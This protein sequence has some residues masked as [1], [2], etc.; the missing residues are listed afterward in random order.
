MKQRTISFDTHVQ[1]PITVYATLNPA[2]GNGWNEP[3]LPASI[4]IDGLEYRGGKQMDDVTY[5]MVM[6]TCEQELKQ[7]AEGWF[8]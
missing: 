2:E 4:S 3:H 8:G 7:E 1:I 5:N 6:R